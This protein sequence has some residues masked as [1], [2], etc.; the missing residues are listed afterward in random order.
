MLRPGADSPA[1]SGDERQNT[2]V[3]ENVQLEKKGEGFS[4]GEAC[5]MCVLLRR[6]FALLLPLLQSGED[7]HEAFV[8]RI[9]DTTS[10][11]RH[12]IPVPPVRPMSLLIVHS[13]R[14]VAL[15]KRE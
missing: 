6:Y 13:N 8:L 1:E 4:T 3:E 15:K 9:W 5:Q 11:A 7:G 14:L 10:I 2:G 12:W